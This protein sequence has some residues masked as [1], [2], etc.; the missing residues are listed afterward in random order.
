M[1]NRN[2]KILILTAVAALVAA[3]LWSVQSD[4]MPAPDELT[5]L[6][7][8]P[9]DAGKPARTD[10]Q[11]PLA[12][13]TF[14]LDLADGD[15]PPAPALDDNDFR[16]TLL[17]NFGADAGLVLAND[18]LIEKLV[19]TVDN[20]TRPQVSERI[21]VV[22]RLP[23]E[24]LADKVGEYDKFYLNP[25][26]YARYDPFVDM[27]ASID[28]ETI[29]ATYRRFYPLL[30]NAYTEIGYP[31]GYFND[32]VVDVIDH[33]LLTPQPNG[34]ILLVRPHVLYKYADVKLE[35]LS[36]G[37]KLMIRMGPKNAEKIKRV[38]RDLRAL[39]GA[40]GDSDRNSALP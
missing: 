5:S 37:Q 36:S 17:E 16:T 21:R 23:N 19:I 33:L 40:T 20:L 2:T 4:F 10:P 9:T 14:A 31:D 15:A 6:E 1:S 13:V 3:A 27:A 22:G 7:P 24:F 26:S 35:A 29:A 12:P 34:P 32:R 25:E 39:I 8:A 18:S 28:P 30:Q 38:L 11:H